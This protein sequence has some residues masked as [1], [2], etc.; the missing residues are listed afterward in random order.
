MLQLCMRPFVEGEGLQYVQIFKCNCLYVL[1]E[2]N[3]PVTATE[4]KD[5]YILELSF[6]QKWCRRRMM[7]FCNGNIVKKQEQYNY[8]LWQTCSYLLQS[9]FG[10]IRNW[11]ADPLTAFLWKWRRD[12]IPLRRLSAWKSY[13]SQQNGILYLVIHFLFRS[14]WQILCKIAPH[15][16][17]QL[18]KMLVTNFDESLL[19]AL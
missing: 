5:N 4:G 15:D 16:S 18:W 9:I 14:R 1:W 12:G 2:R 11:G 10:L 8:P 7:S 13:E 17:Y 19:T 3:S 6:S